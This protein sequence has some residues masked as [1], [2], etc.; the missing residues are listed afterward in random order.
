MVRTLSARLLCA[1]PVLESAGW[2]IHSWRSKEGVWNPLPDQGNRADLLVLPDEL[3]GLLVESSATL[4]MVEDAADFRTE[5]ICDFVIALPSLAEQGL[6]L[7]RK[8]APCESGCETC[9]HECDHDP[10]P[11]PTTGSGGKVN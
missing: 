5:C 7:W 4:A 9:A 2:K 10:D 3:S 6:V 1:V 8:D 11:E